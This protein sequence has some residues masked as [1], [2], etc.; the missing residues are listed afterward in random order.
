MNNNARAAH[1]FHHSEGAREWASDAVTQQEQG[2]VGPH[3]DRSAYQSLAEKQNNI[4]AG[5][6]DDRECE[7][8]INMHIER[9]DLVLIMEDQTISPCNDRTR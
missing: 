5:I 4:G 6:P 8:C 3:W 1:I 9:R 2:S 7:W